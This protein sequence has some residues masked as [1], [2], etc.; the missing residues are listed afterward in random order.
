VRRDGARPG[1][2]VCVTGTLGGSIRGKHLAFTPRVRE[3]RAHVERYQGN[4]HAMMDITD[5]LAIDLDRIAEASGIGA[6]LF[7][8]QLDAVASDAAKLLATEDGRDVRDHVLRD[9]EDFELL[10]VGAIAPG[11]VHLSGLTQV[12][13]MIE[14]PG[15]FLESHDGSRSPLDPKGYEHA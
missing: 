3:A 2:A 9:G 6:V 13:V 14:S 8:E 7:A 10:L 4:L 5:G 15:L 11:P 12:G 1:D